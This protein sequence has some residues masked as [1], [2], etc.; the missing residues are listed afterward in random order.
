MLQNYYQFNATFFWDLN[1]EKH[2]FFLFCLLAKREKNLFER[3]EK[4]RQ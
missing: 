2:L 4:R 3:G 1:K